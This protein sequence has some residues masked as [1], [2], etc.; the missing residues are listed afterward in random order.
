MFTG[1]VEAMARVEQIQPR[2]Q[3]YRFVLDVGQVAEGVAIGD[4]IAVDGACLTAVSIDR[5][6]IGFDV[7]RETVERTAFAALRV[8]DQV[9]VERSMRADGRFHGHFVAGH[10]DGTGRVVEK[11]QDPGQWVL[12]VEAPPRLTAFMIEKGSITLSGVSLTLTDVQDTRF[13]VCL[14]PHTLAITT[15]GVKDVGG[16]I[17]SEV[18]QLGKFVHRLLTAYVPN[19]DA[20]EET[21]GLVV[22]PKQALKL[23]LE[24]LRRRGTYGT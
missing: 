8:R 14:I 6:K 23:T 12:T 11:R 17:N 16:L 9:N 4:S 1:I 13:S 7:I 15:L 19:D 10:V 18:D 3:A 5:T 2:G 24:E 22:D 20:P 21:S